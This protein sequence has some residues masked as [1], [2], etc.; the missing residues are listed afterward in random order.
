MASLR[1]SFSL[2]PAQKPVS[3]R[4][5]CKNSVSLSRHSVLTQAAFT[6]VQASFGW[7]KS[8]A[9]LR[10][11][12]RAGSGSSS[13]GVPSAAPARQHSGCSSQEG[14]C[15]EARPWAQELAQLPSGPGIQPILDLRSSSATCEPP[16]LRF[17]HPHPQAVAEVVP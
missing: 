12:L 7:R 13:E 9:S 1:H 10:T 4:R 16:L 11:M 14:A 5:Q 2:R 15:A 8:Q 3:L 6:D 17:P